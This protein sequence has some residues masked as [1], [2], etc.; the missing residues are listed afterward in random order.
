MHWCCQSNVMMT[1][2]LVT[3][4]RS[5][6]CVCGLYC[7]GWITTSLSHTPGKY[8]LDSR[9]EEHGDRLP[10]VR[11][12]WESRRYHQ[13]ERRS[14]LPHS[15]KNQQDELLVFRVIQSADR[16]IVVTDLL[17]QVQKYSHV[18]R[19]HSDFITNPYHPLRH[20]YVKVSDQLVI[21]EHFHISKVKFC[22]SRDIDIAYTSLNHEVVEMLKKKLGRLFELINDR[23]RDFLFRVPCIVTVHDEDDKLFSSVQLDGN[24]RNTLLGCIQDLCLE[25]TV[26]MWSVPLRYILATKPEE[27]II[28][29]FNIYII[30]WPPFIET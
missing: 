24:L 2:P 23:T 9:N 20:L 17:R 22:L 8:E 4:G 10:T 15:T 29:K 26:G 21:C 28:S 5:Y 19:C 18:V 30:M 25:Q 27:C 1:I 16:N 3:T 12:N 11:R 6:R 7:K 14:G 13:Y